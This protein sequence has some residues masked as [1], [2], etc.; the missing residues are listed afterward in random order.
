MARIRK[1]PQSELLHRGREHTRACGLSGHCI[2]SG[3]GLVSEE[4]Q[5]ALLDTKATLPVVE[6]I[7]NSPR[8]QGIQLRAFREM[9]N[10]E[11]ET[12]SI[13]EI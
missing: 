2:E 13:Q 11:M 4:G 6:A 1:Y 9:K 10:G 3:F 5:L 7:M 12:T 8:Q